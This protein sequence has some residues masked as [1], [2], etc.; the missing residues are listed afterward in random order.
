[1]SAVAASPAFR[2]PCRKNR[3]T[4]PTSRPSWPIRPSSARS[5]CAR[6]QRSQLAAAHDIFPASIYI[7]AVRRFRVWNEI[8]DILQFARV[9][10]GHFM[11]HCGGGGGC[12]HYTRCAHTPPAFSAL[13]RFLVFLRLLPVHGHDKILA[14]RRRSKF[15]PGVSTWKARPGFPR[16]LVLNVDYFLDF[17]TILPPPCTGLYDCSHI[18]RQERKAAPTAVHPCEKGRTN[19]ITGNIWLSD[20]SP[21]LQAHFP[22][23]HSGMIFIR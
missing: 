22:P 20:T 13:A 1:M 4:P 11:E 19:I 23:F 17:H 7:A 16:S 2:R 14:A 18:P 10:H 15:T 9:Q 3:G 6:Y 12:F 5:G 8:T 21:V